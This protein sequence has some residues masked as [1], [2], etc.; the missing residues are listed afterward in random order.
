MSDIIIIIIIIIIIYCNWVAKR[1]YKQ[2]KTQ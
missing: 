2:Q 1:Q